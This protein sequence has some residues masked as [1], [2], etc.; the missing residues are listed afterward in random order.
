MKIVIPE[1]AKNYNLCPFKNEEELNE[2]GL[3]FKHSALADYVIYWGLQSSKLNTHDKF[4]VME[5]GFFYEASFIDTIGAYQCCS[6][7]TK[8][9]YDQIINFDLNNRK[10]AKEIIFSLSQEKQSKYNAVHGKKDL[11]INQNIVLALQNPKDRSICYPSSTNKYYEFIEKC[12]KFYGK[13]LFV[14]LHPWNTGDAA[15][16]LLS[17]VAKYGCEAEKCPISIIENKEFVISY[18]STFAVDC[19]LR[20]V[21]YVQYGL[22][23]FYN[24]FGIHFSNHS[25]PL[26]IEPIPNAEKLV[27]FLIYKYCFYKCM[28]KSKYANMI[29]H[30]ALSNEIFPMND[31]F[32][33]ANNI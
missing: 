15:K 4:G 21:P 32:C 19:L 27:D 10:S 31:E 8:Y 28:I 33:Y 20:G 30:F 29:K 26:N 3:T 16:D 1:Y 17:I 23:T 2:Y 7:N 14:K 6:L 25:L 11:S 24:T 12:C 22:G 5:T 18:N 9:A 13:N